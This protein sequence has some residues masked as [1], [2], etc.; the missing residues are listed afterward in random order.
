M[1]PSW[2]R[3]IDLRHSRRAILLYWAGTPSQSV[4][5]NKKFRSMRKGAAARELS[6]QQSARFIV[7]G[8]GLVDKVT[9][10]AK[11]VDAQSMIRAHFWYKDSQ[12]RW[13]LGKIQSID[14]TRAGSFFV[15]FLDDPGPIKIILR[16]DHYTVDENA[17]RGSWCL[18]RHLRSAVRTGVNRNVDTSR[19]LHG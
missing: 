12:G 9:W 2:E 8:Y 15:R 16:D 7:E 3:E 4:Q 6:R 10:K 14:S 17:R 18:Q 1:R 19:D 5:G 11:F 13:W